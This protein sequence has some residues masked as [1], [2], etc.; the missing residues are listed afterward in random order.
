MKCRIPICFFYYMEEYL[1]SDYFK[2]IKQ[3]FEDWKFHRKN[4]GGCLS[5]LDP[6][7]KHYI[8]FHSWLWSMKFLSVE[9]MLLAVLWELLLKAMIWNTRSII[10]HHIFILGNRF[11]WWCCMYVPQIILRARI[12]QLWRLMR[13]HRHRWSIYATTVCFPL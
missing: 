10:F 5:E 13:L 6:L 7:F 11:H 12:I 9:H 3:Y 1:F 4:S 2:L 8:Q